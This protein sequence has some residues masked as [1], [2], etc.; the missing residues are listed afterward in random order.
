[1]RARFADVAKALIDI[2]KHLYD[3]GDT[4][5]GEAEYYLD[6]G[7]VPAVRI[8]FFTADGVSSWWVTKLPDCLVADWSAY[9]RLKQ[10]EMHEH[11]ERLKNGYRREGS[12][13]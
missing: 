6:I 11:V 8:Q 9:L 7:G 2:A 10:V 1:M 5:V 3:R 4:G 12:T 13:L